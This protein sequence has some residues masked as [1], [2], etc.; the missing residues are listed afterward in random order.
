[1][2]LRQLSAFVAV[3]EEGTFT[4]AAE[5]LGV[6]QPAVSQAIGRLET[7]LGLVLFERSS[8]RVTL[9]SAGAAFLPDA[10]AVLGRLAQAEQ[11][12]S[13]LAAGRRGVVR[14]ATTPGAPGLVRAL[15]AHQQAA[16]PGVRVELAHV[17]HAPKLRAV[18]DGEIDVAL[19]HS[20][21]PTSGLTFT[22]IWREP[23]RPVVS[24][25]HS[26]AGGDAVALRALAGDPLVLVAGEGTTGVREQFTALCRDAGF[27]P[28]TGPT[29]ANLSD[30]LVHIAQSTGWTLLRAS[31]TR[32][33][34]RVGVVALTIRD[35][36]AP[37]RLW[38]AHRTE[39][40]AP[41]RSLVALAARLHRAH[42]L[43][44]PPGDAGGPEE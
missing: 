12:A 35:R 32:D 39:P 38:L 30:A 27:E 2:E 36:L 14:L 23:W 11:T 24:A 43:I 26:L 8:R 1:M 4:N 28:I 10:R 5:R 42:Q 17:R 40:A 25:A 18:V 33:I 7:E 31:N 41:T 37:A 34:E 13:D 44:P 19:V 21:P 16:H 6:V 15:L 20:A 22:E 3:A 9:T 29:H